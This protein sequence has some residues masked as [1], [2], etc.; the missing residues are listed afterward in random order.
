MVK[1]QINKQKND[2]TTHFRILGQGPAF[3]VLPISSFKGFL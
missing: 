3:K 1:G 2:P